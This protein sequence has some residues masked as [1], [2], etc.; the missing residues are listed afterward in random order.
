[1]DSS[2]E[3][4]IQKQPVIDDDFYEMMKVKPKPKTSTNYRFK[5]SADTSK[6]Y[7]VNVKLIDKT[8]E[9]LVDPILFLSKLNI[10][11]I[12]KG[13]KIVPGIEKARI[14]PVEMFDEKHSKDEIK[15]DTAP[16]APSEFDNQYI[17]NIEKTQILITIK[18]INVTK[19]EKTERVTKPPEFKKK[20]D[21]EI[22][23][24]IDGPETIDKPETI[25]RDFEIGDYK[26][27]KRLPQVKPNILIK[28]DSY[29]LNNRE[30]F[31]EFIN[32]LFLP[33]RDEI[34]QQEQNIKD[35]KISIS[36][37]DYSKKD[38]SLLIHQKIVRDYINIFTPYR[39]LLLFHGLGSGKTCSS[40]AISEGLK[41]DKPVII[42]TPAS[43]RDNYVQELKKC[44]DLM[45][46]KNQYWEFISIETNPEYIKHLS[47]LLH[48]PEEYI[49]RKGGAWF[50]NNSKEPNY[51]TEISLDETKKKSLD[52]QIDKMIS[53]KYKFLS[54]NGLRNNS[55]EWLQ[56]TQDNKINPFD[57]RVVVIDEAHNLISRIINK[58]R[59]RSATSLSY[60]M[61]NFLMSAENC[62]IILLTG[63]PIINYPNEIAVLFNILRGYI[64]CYKFKITTTQT[65]SKNTFEK[66]LKKNEIYNYIDYIDYNGKTKE[67]QIYKNPFGFVNTSQEA[68]KQVVFNN[69]G[70]YSGEFVEKLKSLFN[71][72]SIKFVE[73]K[74]KNHIVN[75]KALPDL[76]ED[77]KYL[78]L[79][80]NGELK[81]QE[82]FMRRI[83]GLTS[84]F[85][86][87]QEELMPTY[88]EE[89][90]FEVIEIPM[91]NSQFKIYNEARAQ[92]RKIESNSKKRKK[93]NTVAGND[94]V[95]NDSVSTYRIFSRAFCNFVFPKQD[96]ERPMPKVGEKI[97][98]VLHDL[99]ESE[100]LDETVL[101]DDSKEDIRKKINEMDGNYEQED[102]ENMNRENR[103]IKDEGYSVRIQKALLSLKQQSSKYLNKTYLQELSPKFLNILENIQD[104]ENF[105]GIHLLYSQFKTLEGIGIFKLVLEENMLKESNTIFV[106]LKLEKSG[107][108][109][110]DL[111]LDSPIVTKIQEESLNI[112][113]F[114]SYTGSESREER[115]II[116]NILNSNWNVVPQNIIA[117]IKEYIPNA[118]NNNN[119][120]V[121]KV[122]MISS[123]G[124]EGISLKNVRYVHIMEPYWHP[125]RKN[126]VIGRARRICSHSNLPPDLQFV[127]VMV[128]LMKFSDEQLKTDD[129]L[130][131]IK[132][133][134]SKIEKDPLTGQ[135]LVHTTDQFLNE[136]SNR[137]EAITNK[138]LNVVKSSAIDCVIH[139]KEDSKEDVKCYLINSN[140][141]TYDEDLIYVSNYENQKNDESMNLN[142]KTVKDSYKAVTINGKKYLI[143]VL[144][145]S[146]EFPEK[147]FL[148]DYNLF[149]SDKKQ[150]SKIGEFTLSDD[151]KPII[152]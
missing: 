54:Y 116:L 104:E 68:N 132:H 62:K 78:F 144:H 127:K 16:S 102:V 94:E 90:D 107:N 23:P 67:L 108:G 24:D 71:S 1:M 150:L 47:V 69:E 73:D 5:P 44:G 38:F 33:Y 101:E 4:P 30:I 77:F 70:M 138:L 18:Q 91:S 88:K 96:I 114:A 92:E 51:E 82:M 14:D 137:K 80:E 106:D 95:F 41:N 36:C 142:K 121:I 130:E 64:K 140:S 32:R 13:D 61:Y 84:Y 129:A 79:N 124:A 103:E 58:I 22:Y 115:E 27:Q 83:I 7:S 17:R 66:L 29:Y 85:R 147:R 109:S 149:K 143:N 35:G 86:S 15:K 151:G 75:Y 31:I 148:Y 146:S 76:F 43:L 37:D 89:Q 10:G 99:D 26:L 55:S 152:L 59:T 139:S 110:Y 65:L 123:S 3:K 53:Y 128:Y 34:L 81:N 45:Y 87:A 2:L 119:G 145:L 42:M 21:K 46:K 48:L 9:E 52:E 98:N 111:V 6:S 39:G 117:K 112:K 133:D 8:Q 20:K 126:Q 49:M 97:E 122:L 134:K 141:K 12:N 11:V 93:K 74:E 105:S 100:N 25:D 63:T 57:N 19:R 40:I 50:I 135:Y 136:L 28:A 60:K 118:E 131:I 113:F 72:N 56:I 120:E 125:V